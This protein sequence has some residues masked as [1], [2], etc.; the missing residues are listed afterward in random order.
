MGAPA[1]NQ[2]GAKGR[3][4]TA[5]IER[6]VA[7]FGG[8][9]GPFDDIEP[10]PLMKGMDALADRFVRNLSEGDLAYFKEF[11]DR[12]EGR[13]VQP[14]AGEEGRPPMVIRLETG[15]FG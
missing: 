11:G 1:G 2:N 15:I 3:K 13:P 4:W 7:R 14:V 10:S 9:T 8:Q 5:A 12:I 6:A